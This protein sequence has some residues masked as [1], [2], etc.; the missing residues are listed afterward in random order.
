MFYSYINLRDSWR[1]RDHF[2]KDPLWKWKCRIYLHSLLKNHNGGLAQLVQSICL[3]SRGSA[4][5]SRQPPHSKSGTYRLLLSRCLF[6]LH[7]IC[8]QLHIYRI[9]LKCRPRYRLIVLGHYLLPYT[10]VNNFCRIQCHLERIKTK[11]PRSWFL[12]AHNKLLFNFNQNLNVIP[13]PSAIEFFGAILSIFDIANSASA[14]LL[15]PSA[16]IGM[17]TTEVAM[18][19][20]D[21]LHCRHWLLLSHKCRLLLKVFWWSEIKD[22]WGGTFFYSIMEYSF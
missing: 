1:V 3:T 10:V 15:T 7:K 9:G 13:T 14:F 8:T 16:Q 17:P 22:Y 5:R 18:Q 4:V 20:V 2:S 6:Y 12:G 21:K 19:T 11:S